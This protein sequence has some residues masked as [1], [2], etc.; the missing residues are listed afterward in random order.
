MRLL[1]A[2]WNFPPRVGGAE[3]FA[4]GLC[5]ALS[6]E[7]DVRILTGRPSELPASSHATLERP[8]VPGFPAFAAWL[9]AALTWHG[10]RHR[11]H[12]VVAVN[13]AVGALCRP[14]T[15][16]LRLPQATA[17]LGSDLVWQRRGYRGVVRWGLRHTPLVVAISRASAE[18]ALD[19]GAPP[20]GT[21]VIPPGVD[22]DLDPDSSTTD[23]PAATD[24]PVVLFVGRAV[25]RKGLAPFIEHALPRI[26]DNVPAQLWVVGEEPKGSLVH[27][28]GELARAR[29]LASGALRDSVRFLGGL[30]P[31]QLRG[32]YR[33]A[34]VLVLPA[35]EAPGDVEGFGI[36]L[37][38]AGL[39]GVPVVGTRV[40]GIPDAV[41][42]GETGLLAPPGDWDAIAERVV[43]V[44]CDRELAA[45]LGE[46][47]RRRASTQLSWRRI[48]QRW[49][50]AL[51]DL[52][53]G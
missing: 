9:P 39:F 22:L 7:H 20:E 36:V 28:A 11:P 51:Q 30:S 45:R 15:A 3:A 23:L 34:D 6:A 19:A 40:G 46:G 50:E 43:R 17:V 2:T 8:P 27:A 13:A 21:L 48:E 26:L 42:E 52:I 44:L 32:A 37:I 49:S 31:E 47:G 1:V 53:S 12:A 18:L 38:E 14:F 35:I 24:R 16:L 5:E 33:R 4:L 10:L 29:H 25:P 41:V